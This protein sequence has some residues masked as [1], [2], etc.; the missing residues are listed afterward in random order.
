MTETEA[1]QACAQFAS[2]HPDRHTHRWRPR[3]ELDGSWSV[4]KIALA[5]EGPLGTETRA[6][7]KPPTPDDPRTVAEQTLGPNVGPVF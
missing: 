6:E 2:E 1:R 4:V 3:E 5:P 7:E